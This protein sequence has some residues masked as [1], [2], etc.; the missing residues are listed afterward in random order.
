MTNDVMKNILFGVL[1]VILGVLISMSVK[2]KSEIMSPMSIEKIENYNR[3]LSV[4]EN[5]INVDREIISH[6][7]Q[8]IG[9]N[10]SRKN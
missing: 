6:I 8:K 1:S 2:E 10:Y 7:K 3:E 4:I 9:K 5:Q